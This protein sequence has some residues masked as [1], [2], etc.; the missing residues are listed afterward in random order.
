TLALDRGG[1][2]LAHGPTDHVLREHAG[3]LAALGCRLPL[4][5][6]LEHAGAPAPL[7]D[8]ATD[9]W[10]VDRARGT[11]A[12]PARPAHGP[13]LLRARGLGVLRGAPGR[14]RRGAR[15]V[16][17]DVDLDVR[18]GELLAVV[19]PNG[20]GKST[21]LRGLAGEERTTGV[22]TTD[23]GSVALVL[24]DPEHQL[25]ART[26][27]E[28]VAWSA[29]GARRTGPRAVRPR[30]RRRREALPALRRRAATPVPRGR[31]RARPARPPRRRAAVR[32]RPH[33]GRRRRARPAGPGRR[34]RCRGRRH[35][36]PRA[37]RRGRRPPGRRRRR[38]PRRRRPGAPRPRRRRAAGPGRAAPATR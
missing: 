20:G 34:G 28:E 27:R 18:A 7:G 9:D 5:V 23:A 37:R 3:A 16:V 10:L 13:A 6:R 32:A 21:L 36:R 12:R 33:P 25:L 38:P 30:P 17:R 29:R 14:R 4:A 24:Q 22:V 19:G 31:D 11:P 1:R 2:V 15:P 8:P 35:A 26:V